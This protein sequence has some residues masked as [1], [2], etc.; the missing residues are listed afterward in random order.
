MQNSVDCA[1][2]RSVGLLL[3]YNGQRFFKA[4]KEWITSL[5]QAAPNRVAVVLVCWSSRPRVISSLQVWAGPRHLLPMRGIQQNAPWMLHSRLGN[6]KDSGFCLACLFCGSQLP[7]RER[8]TWQKTE[9]GQQPTGSKELKPFVQRTTRNWIPQQPRACSWKWSRPSTAL[10]WLQPLDCSLWETHR[11]QA[12]HT[13]VPGP[14]KTW[15]KSVFLFFT[16]HFN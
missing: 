11:T 4:P 13:P 15:E 14:Q 16:F 10:R 3:T 5:Q 2:G 6:K 9:G 7:C 1:P 8:L 12:G